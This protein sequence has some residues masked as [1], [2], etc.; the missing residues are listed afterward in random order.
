[1]KLS[2]L[3]L[4]V[5]LSAVTAF[6]VSKYTA[7]PAPSAAKQETAFERVMRTG[8]LRCGYIISPPFL[9]V[10]PAT[11]TK[12]GLAIDYVTAIG[13]ELGLKIE[14]AEEVGWGVF[15]EGLKAGRYDALCYPLWEAG[16][17]AK[18]ALFTTPLYDSDLSMLS[19]ADDMR[20]KDGLKSINKTDVIMATVEGDVSQALHAQQFPL[21]KELALPA[22]TDSGQYFMNIV[23]R[24]ADVGPVFKYEMEK[25]NE[26]SPTKLKIIGN[27]EPVQ[28]FRTGLTVAQ[29]EVNLKLMLD[30]AIHTLLRSGEAATIIAK[31]PGVSVPLNQN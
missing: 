19:R 18:V 30:S 4:V 8:T 6:A 31:Y 3:A 12:S 27:N 15:A 25:F 23:T 21:T 9:A 16:Q 26:N 5:A 14:W 1:M 22:G 20:F 13:R 29:G 11:G 2:H 7:A 17:R 28:S 10:D 24:K